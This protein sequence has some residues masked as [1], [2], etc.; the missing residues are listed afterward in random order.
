MSLE[1]TA[2]RPAPAFTVD[3]ESPI[4]GRPFLVPLYVPHFTARSLLPIT[5]E[6]P[7]FVAYY[8]VDAGDGVTFS[9]SIF[10][11]QSGAEEANRRAADFV[12]QNLASF[13]PNPPQ[14]TAGE[15]V[16]HMAR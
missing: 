9:V 8:L 10:E 16:A 12:Q 7:G 14:T 4:T 6:V 5:S 13:L 2:P 15:V 3:E 11:D 1:P